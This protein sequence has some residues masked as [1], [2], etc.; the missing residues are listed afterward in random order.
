MGAALPV[1]MAAMVP[2]TLI[3]TIISASSL[4]LLGVL[5]AAAARL[6][7][8]PMGRGA[9]RVMFWG[10]AAMLCTALVGRLFGT[11]VA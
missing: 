9:V 11:S 1:V 7:G 10:A 8:A 2:I 6:G 5:G 4:A 3:T